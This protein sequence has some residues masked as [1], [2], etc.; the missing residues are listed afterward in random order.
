MYAMTSTKSDI[1][2]MVRK[3]S[4]YTN[5]PGQIHWQAMYRILKYLKNTMDYGIQ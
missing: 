3:L 2:F 5:N 1:A 4:R